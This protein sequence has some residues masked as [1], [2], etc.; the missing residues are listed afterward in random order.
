MKVCIITNRA[1]KAQSSDIEGDALFI[2]RSLE[3]DIQIH[4]EY[5]SRNHL[6]LWR[7]GNRYFI[8]DLK[9]ENGTFINTSQI[10]PGIDYEIQEGVAIIIGTSVICLGGRGPEDVFAFLDPVGP[11]KR[12]S[13][14]TV[15]FL[16]NNIMTSR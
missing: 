8:R 15:V 4:D 2:G 14:T 10:C 1:N 9:S 3:N 12:F 16:G 11:S 7:E 5:V 6:R 13:D